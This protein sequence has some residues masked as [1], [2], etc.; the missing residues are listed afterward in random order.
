MNPPV[1]RRSPPLGKA[2]WLLLG[3]AC[4]HIHQGICAWQARHQERELVTTGM[5]DIYVLFGHD[6]VLTALGM[7]LIGLLALLSI[8]MHARYR[9]WSLVL[10]VPQQVLMTI[11]GLTAWECIQDGKFADGAVY[12]P[13]FISVDQ[14]AQFYL[15]LAHSLLMVH[16]FVWDVLFWGES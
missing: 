4:I 9:L 11:S 8:G 1:I 13:L 14:P 7:V 16:I 6:R 15:P 10:I 2:V 12:D 5:R 3:P